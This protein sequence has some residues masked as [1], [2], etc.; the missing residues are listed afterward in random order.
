MEIDQV[1]DGQTEETIGG[2]LFEFV[3]KAD[4][5]VLIDFKPGQYT[6]T[7]VNNIKASNGIIHEVDGIFF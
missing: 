4:G 1:N 3:K 6:I 2:E 5:T 7:K